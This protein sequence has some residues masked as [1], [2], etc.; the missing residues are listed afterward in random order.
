MI[1][2]RDKI[3]LRY[4]SDVMEVIIRY[5]FIQAADQRVGASGGGGGLCLDQK[6]PSELSEL[7]KERLSFEKLF[8][9]FSEI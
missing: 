8:F 3:L 5:Q 6:E 9:R 1:S 4:C 7:G 2:W